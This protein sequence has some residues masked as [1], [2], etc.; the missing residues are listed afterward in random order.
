[1][2][3]RNVHNGRAEG[4]EGLFG[5]ARPWVMAVGQVSSGRT[6]ALSQSNRRTKKRGGEDVY[7]NGVE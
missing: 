3:V 1:M 4:E 5:G 6:V 7:H 2:K